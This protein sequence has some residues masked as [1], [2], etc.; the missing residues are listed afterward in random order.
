MANNTAIQLL[1]PDSPGTPINIE[2]P[3]INKTAILIACP[4]DTISLFILYSPLGLSP[5]IAS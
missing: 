1:L 3:I 5:K 2:V 4:V